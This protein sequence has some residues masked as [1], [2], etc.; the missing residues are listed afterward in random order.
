MYA[1]HFGL[2]NC[3]RWSYRAYRCRRKTLV[4]AIVPF[5]LRILETISNARNLAP[6]FMVFIIIRRR[7][8]AA[9]A[10]ATY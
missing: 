1:N 10:I 5:R 4:S 9:G 7:E 6:V 3:D 2:S 8:R